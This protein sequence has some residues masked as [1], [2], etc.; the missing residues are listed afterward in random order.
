MRSDIPQAPLTHEDPASSTLT[1]RRAWLRAVLALSLAAGGLGR[2]LAT[3][4]AT[5]AVGHPAP[6]LVLHT[7]DGRSINS[8]DL[9]GK[10]VILTFWATW[11]E[12]CRDELPLLSAYA[13]RNA[14]RGLQVLGFSLDG[15]D[16]LSTVREVAAGLSFPVGLLGS[17]WA[18]DYGR[19]WRI[20]VSFTIGRTGLL[21]DN[22]WDDKY[23]VWTSERL[24]RVVTPLLRQ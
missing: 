15:A 2:P 9:F 3:H 20:P 22:G 6:P 23:P 12:P 11:C 1:A 13:A 10:V 8:A 7:L 18:G 4:A 24:Q 16:E 17:A 19:M 21:A 14:D 5:L